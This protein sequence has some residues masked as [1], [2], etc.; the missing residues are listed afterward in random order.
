MSKTIIKLSDWDNIYDLDAFSCFDRPIA[1]IMEKIDKD[2][3]G[4]FIMFRK[5]FQIFSQDDTEIRELDFGKKELHFG[6]NIDDYI[7]RQLGLKY[8][9]QNVNNRLKDAVRPLIDAQTPVLVP[10]NLFELYYSVRYKSSNWPHTFLV[11]GYDSDNDL[12]YILDY[13]QSM[14]MKEYLADVA[15]E[16]FA[17]RGDDLESAYQS[18]SFFAKNPTIRYLL[19]QDESIN[20]QALLLEFLGLLKDKAANTYPIEKRLAEEII[21][22]SGPDL[23]RDSEEMNECFYK[24][25]RSSKRKEALLSEMLRQIKNCSIPDDGIREA[26]TLQENIMNSWTLLINKFYMG[27]LK[28]SPK[29]NDAGLAEVIQLEAKLYDL[30][31]ALVSE[32]ADPVTYEL[33]SL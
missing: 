31:Y 25:S 8:V 33:G 20:K 4:F 29:L 15:Y 9:E 21:A 1:I 28:G 7:F 19:K 2:L 27:F 11:N 32:A 22:K 17:I 10:G 3:A 18:F 16:R 13:I 14:D 26:E 12:F 30:A 6:E 5:L 24:L 23:D